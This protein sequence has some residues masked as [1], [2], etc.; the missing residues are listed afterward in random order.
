MSE[1]KIP[2][3]FVMTA[4][5]DEVVLMIGIPREHFEAVI[6]TMG[7]AEWAQQV[8]DGFNAGKAAKE[9]GVRATTRQFAIKEPGENDAN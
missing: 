8:I 5:N 7:T 4:T 9:I 1:E 6:H 2:V 3:D